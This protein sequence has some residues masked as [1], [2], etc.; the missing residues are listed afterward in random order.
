MSEPTQQTVLLSHPPGA[1]QAGIA[2]AHDAVGSLGAQPVLLLIVVINIA[3]IA[4][5]GFFLAQLESTRSSLMMSTLDIIRAC[6]LET[7]PLG[8]NAQRIQALEEALI[9]EKA[10]E[11]DGAPGAP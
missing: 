4:I 1:I 9:E 7:A 11:K 8:A 10:K 6:V 5:G 2:V 3:F